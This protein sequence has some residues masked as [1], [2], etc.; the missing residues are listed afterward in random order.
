LSCATASSLGANGL[1]FFRS[2]VRLHYACSTVRGYLWLM[3]SILTFG[4][5]CQESVKRNDKQASLDT[6]TRV[7]LLSADNNRAHISSGGPSLYAVI[8]SGMLATHGLSLSD[9][10]RVCLKGR[11]CS[12]ASECLCSAAT[13]SPV[14]REIHSDSYLANP[15]T[16][17]G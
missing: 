11:E 4:V 13:Y 6:S 9:T 5:S 17:N 16:M 14:F 10:S 8:A 3:N 15:A 2:P 1:G 7:S 12:F